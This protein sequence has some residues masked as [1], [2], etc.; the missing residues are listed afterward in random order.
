MSEVHT[1][2]TAYYFYFHHAFSFFCSYPSKVLKTRYRSWAFCDAEGGMANQ[3]NVQSLPTDSHFSGPSKAAASGTL[4]GPSNDKL[5]A[6]LKESEE[7]STSLLESADALERKSS[8]MLKPQEVSVEIAHHPAYMGKF[9]ELMPN[10]ERL[11]LQLPR[12]EGEYVCGWG[13][14]FINISCTFPINKAI[15]RQQLQGIHGYK[16]VRQLKSEGLRNLYRGLLP[17][18]LQK[19]TTLS[20]M[21]G[22]Y[23][24][25]RLSLD[26]KFP[27]VPH[28]ATHAAAA[29]LAGTLE[30]TLTPFERIQTLLQD[31]TYQKRFNNSVHAAKELWAFGIGEYYRGG[32]IIFLRNGP[33]NVFFFLGREFL[34]DRAPSLDNVS[35]R[36]AKDFICGACLGAMISTGFF[37][38]NVVKTRMQSRLGG[39]FYG[40]WY[41]F[42][43]VWVER[44]RSVSNLFRGFH[45]NYTRSFI[46]WGIINASYE[47]LLQLFRQLRADGRL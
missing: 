22:S 19:T 38:L 1:L 21:F 42:Q 41:T 27:T 23:H 5:E 14:A 17:P 3:T 33:S 46:S 45:L 28:P 13:A 37:P 6:I 15:F 36:F 12:I 34:S 32:T 7:D 40:V 26:R 20:I 11:D 9:Q 18:L 31:C 2:Q 25:F 4:F 16:A 44:N 29:M 24:N 10:L 35:G 43:E 8:S 30:M 39:P 47:Y